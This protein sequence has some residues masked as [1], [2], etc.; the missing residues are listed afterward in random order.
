[1]A[2]STGTNVAEALRGLGVRGVLVQMAKND[3]LLKLV[4]EMPQCYCPK[5]SS[6]FEKRSTPPRS[7]A[8]NPDHYP[9]PKWAGGTLVPGNVRLAHV[10]CNNRDVGRKK[11][12]TT[13]LNKKMSLSEIADVLNRRKEPRPH[14]HPTWTARLVRQAFIE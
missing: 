9:I 6:F 11:K 7:W 10:L 1:M 12:I 2:S 5:G 4:C 14:G 3:Q 13:M 8:P